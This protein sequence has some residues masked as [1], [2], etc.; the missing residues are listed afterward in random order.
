MNIAL[1]AEFCIKSPNIAVHL[2]ELAA[3]ATTLEDQEGRLVMLALKNPSRPVRYADVS[4][5][6]VA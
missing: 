2:E 1:R 5:A 3:A 4:Q 6:V